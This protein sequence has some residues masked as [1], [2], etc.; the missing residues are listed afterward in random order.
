[1]INSVENYLELNNYKL[2]EIIQENERKKTKL[3]KVKKDSQYYIVK[4]IGKESP[5]DIKNKFFI[6]VEYYK[7]HQQEYLPKFIESNEELLIL[8]FIQ[9][10]SLRETLIDN[11]LDT[12]IL[13]LLIKNVQEIYINSKRKNKDP[14]NF[15]NVFSHLS[16]L[17]QSGPIQTKD[18]K[19]SFYKRILNKLILLVLKFKLRWYI[20]RIDKEDLKNGFVHGDLHYNNIIINNGGDVK[21]IDF[22]NIRYDGFFDFDIMYLYAMLEINIDAESEEMKILQDAI[23]N[24]LRNKCLIKIYSLFRYSVNLNNRFVV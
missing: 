18:I 8:E 21:F 9:G 10:K 5:I 23:N 20:S 15:K 13:A 12:K 17:L 2:V 22:E 7:N 19:V 16:N 14:N 11:S 6:E 1:M 4:A 24:L 3:I